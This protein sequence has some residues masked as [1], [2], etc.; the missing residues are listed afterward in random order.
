MP[1][2]TKAPQETPFGVGK[3][4]ESA[5]GNRD[6]GDLASALHKNFG[7]AAGGVTAQLR[8]LFQHARKGA[9]IIETKAGQR[10]GKDNAEAQKA[11]KGKNK[12]ARQADQIEKRGL[13][14]SR[15]KRMIKLVAAL[16]ART[17]D[18]GK[19]VLREHLHAEKNI[20]KPILPVAG[21]RRMLR[22]F[23]QTTQVPNCV[24]GEKIGIRSVPDTTALPQ[25]P[26][27]IASLRRSARA[28]TRN[29]L[30]H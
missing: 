20:A 28:T 8:K 16:G 26:R 19:R 18:R 2:I 9:A 17:V 4:L 24:A 5:I 29:N 13:S 12:S 25:R 7:N 21:D 1:D 3:T 10:I 15:I 22:R 27:L 11:E 6:F 14:I 23:D 30:P